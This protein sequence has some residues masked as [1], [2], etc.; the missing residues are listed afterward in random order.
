MSPVDAKPWTVAAIAATFLAALAAVLSPLVGMHHGDAGGH[1]VPLVAS[2]IFLG[3]LLVQVV[4]APA[5]TFAWR[6]TPPGPR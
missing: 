4:R 3:I 6:L 5:V 2:A 1:L